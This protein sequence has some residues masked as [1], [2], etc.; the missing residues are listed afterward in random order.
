MDNKAKILSNEL[1][2]IDNSINKRITTCY[3]LRSP[4][5]KKIKSLLK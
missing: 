5:G 4:L 2:I 3:T 1:Q